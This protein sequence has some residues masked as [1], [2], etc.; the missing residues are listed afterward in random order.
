M[1]T[2]GAARFTAWLRQLHIG[3]PPGMLPSIDDDKSF[4]AGAFAAG[5]VAEA[6]PLQLTRAYAAFFNDGVYVTP[7]REGGA[8]V[9][10]RVMKS[11][12]ATA[13]VPMLENTVAGD[14]R[15]KLAQVPGAR[16]AGKTGT[17]DVT[18]EAGA[19]MTYASFVGSVL[20]REPRFVALVGME[21]PEGKANGVTAAAPA[22]GRLAARIVNER[23]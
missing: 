13:I 6:T 21:V 16:A 23:L 15:G 9:E 3:E 17:A 4:R 10:T 1:D 5:E 11:T 19:E 12:T 14:G 18:G 8:P 22:W 2:L 7:S 20:D